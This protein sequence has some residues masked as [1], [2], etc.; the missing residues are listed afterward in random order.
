MTRLRVTGYLAF[1]FFLFMAL[2]GFM[3]QPAALAL[4]ERG[5]DLSSISPSQKSPSNE[6]IK[7]SCQYPVLS[8]Y[9]GTY[10]TYSVDIQYIGGE[11]SRLFDLKVKVPDGF[12]YSLSPGYGE[13]TEI[14][15]IRLDPKKTYPDTLKLTVR[16]YVWL[17][18]EPGDYSVT[19]E[20]A[21]GTLKGSIDLKAIVTAKYDLSLKTDTGRLNTNATAGS[22][23]YLKMS[24]T[25]TG[26]GN[27]K[28]L[29]LAQS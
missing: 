11:E 29:T 26:S 10:F 14:A 1:A 5:G 13:G 18:P 9:A 27:L 7:L 23:N 19:L 8:S 20:A 28:K 2:A 12:N 17:V 15:A 4:P 24:I 6:E 3:V 16:P 22:D 25:N 21:S